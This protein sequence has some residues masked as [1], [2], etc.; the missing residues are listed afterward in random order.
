MAETIHGV[1]APC[2]ETDRSGSDLQAQGGLCDEV[3]LG[4]TDLSPMEC[5]L[6]NRAN[7][8]SHIMDDLMY[9]IY[10]IIFFLKSIFIFI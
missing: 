1:W 6:R 3:D 9:I 2:T 8:K 4:W 7:R 5:R 10:Y